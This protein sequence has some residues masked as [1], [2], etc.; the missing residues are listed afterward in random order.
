[1]G[2]KQ[3]GPIFNHYL[4]NINATVSKQ[5][6]GNT[7]YLIT[8]G[9]LDFLLYYKK[10]YISTKKQ[11]SYIYMGKD[12]IK[13]SVTN[14]LILESYTTKRWSDKDL[15]WF[16]FFKVLVEEEGFR[17]RKEEEGWVLREINEETKIHLSVC[18][19]KKAV[20]IIF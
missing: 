18:M 1:M 10:R 20:T 7:Y 14:Y 3:L 6:D 13:W 11:L 12:Y 17:K 19:D 8:L 15:V 4:R 5:Q 2:R 16:T 9:L